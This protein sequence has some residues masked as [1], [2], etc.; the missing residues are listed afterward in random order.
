MMTI[1]VIGYEYIERSGSCEEIEKFVGLGL[2][3]G[4]KQWG[5]LTHFLKCAGKTK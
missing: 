5:L 2:N 3:Q 4:S 1:L